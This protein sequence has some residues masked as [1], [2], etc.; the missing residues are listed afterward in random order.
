MGVGGMHVHAWVCIDVCVYVHRI[1][2]SIYKC[3]QVHGCMHV[4]MAVDYAYGCACVDMCVH[5]YMGAMWACAYMGVHG[6]VWF[7]SVVC[8]WM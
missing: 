5:E 1:H 7:K 8:V 4:Y 2:G 6:H 3:I